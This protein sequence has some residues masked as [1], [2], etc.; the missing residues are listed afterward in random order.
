ML[1]TKDF[2][3]RQI[4]FVR[5]QDHEKICFRNDNILIKDKD[6]TIKFQTTCYLLFALYIVGTLTITSPILQQAQRFGFSIIL[7]NFS[8]SVAPQSVT[9]RSI[10]FLFTTGMI[11]ASIGT[12]I[13]AILAF[14]RKE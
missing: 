6:D 10:C 5:L 14:S 8:G 12:F 1:S 13:P 2:Q 9:I 7:M 4:V 3:E 11:P